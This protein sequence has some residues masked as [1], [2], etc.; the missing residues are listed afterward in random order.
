MAMRGPLTPPRAVPAGARAL[1]LVG[2]A[3]EVAQRG[4]DAA[5]QGRTA[6]TEVGS[7]AAWRIAAADSTSSHAWS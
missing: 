5:E 1:E 2:H 7:A 3:R 4:L 6:S